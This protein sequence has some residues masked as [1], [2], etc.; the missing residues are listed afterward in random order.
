MIRHT[1][2]SSTY[3]ARIKPCSPKPTLWNFLFTS[4]GP[5]LHV[6]STLRAA[7]P[8]FLF[9]VS[10]VPGGRPTCP[11]HFAC[12]HTVHFSCAPF[13]WTWSDDPP[14][15]L[16]LGLQRGPRAFSGA[17]KTFAAMFPESLCEPLKY[18]D[19]Y[20]R[21]RPSA[22]LRHTMHRAFSV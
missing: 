4:R 16:S 21:F 10:R 6:L 13:P 7:A 17:R 1:P 11:L 19:F 18:L 5:P 8:P 9:S 20:C 12:H 15:P 3:Q 22:E 14:P 2:Q